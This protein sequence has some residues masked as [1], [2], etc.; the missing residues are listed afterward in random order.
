MP[1]QDFIH[2]LAVLEEQYRNTSK[3]IEELKEQYR[4]DMQDIK[5]C[6]H[7][8]QMQTSTWKNVFWGIS[9]A[10]TAMLG[11]LHWLLDLVGIDFK[12]L[13]HT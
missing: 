1:E 4:D 12:N 2:R 8:I 13:F 9:I 5:N 6:L 3:D 10:V 7:L 11:G